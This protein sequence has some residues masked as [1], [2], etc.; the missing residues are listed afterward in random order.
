[1]EQG[2]VFIDASGW[3]AIISADDRNHGAAKLAYQQIISQK[4]RILTTNW[5]LYEALS[6]IKDKIGHT[7][8]LSL[9]N[10]VKQFPSV[11]LIKVTDDIETAAIGLFFRYEDKRWGVVDCT[12]LIVMEQTGC[13]RALAYDLHFKEASRQRGFQL[14]Q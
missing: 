3:V 1:M 13:S 5:T 7:Q 2:P 10:L 11:S 14:I 9:W 12:S 6:I 8:A 4:T